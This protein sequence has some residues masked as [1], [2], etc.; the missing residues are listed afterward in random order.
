MLQH[1]FYGCSER[2]LSAPASCQSDLT[3]LGERDK[4]TGREL[5]P[6]SGMSQPRRWSHRERR[7]RLLCSNT[8]RRPDQA[9]GW[10]TTP[11]TLIHKS[12][13]TTSNLLKGQLTI[14]HPYHAPERKRK[15]DPER[16]IAPPPRLEMTLRLFHPRLDH[17][18]FQPPPLLLPS[19][20]LRSPRR[21]RRRDPMH[22]RLFR[23]VPPLP[24]TTRAPFADRI[25]R[26]AGDVGK[27][28]AGGVERAAEGR[29]VRVDR[30]LLVFPEDAIP[31]RAGG[32]HAAGRGLCTMCYVQAGIT[33]SQR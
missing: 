27:V 15:R 30:Y 9:A 11:R 1:L 2:G 12:T 14:D 31:D 29:D 24:R 26:C 32:G 20:F 6:P 5:R 3:G 21:R 19:P 18:R 10:G 23:Q 8:S 4:L 22:P 33:A 25:A 13:P 16:D 28:E 17:P 7:A